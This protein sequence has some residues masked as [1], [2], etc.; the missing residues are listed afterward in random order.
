MPAS[1]AALAGNPPVENSYGST[2][3]TT[4]PPLAAP[5]NS[6]PENACIV[7]TVPIPGTPFD[8]H[9][10]LT[11]NYDCNSMTCPA[12]SKPM[13]LQALWVTTRT[14]PNGAVGPNGTTNATCNSAGCHTAT[15]SGG[16]GN[17]PIPPAANRSQTITNARSE[18]E[19]ISR[20]LRVL[21]MYTRIENARAEARSGGMETVVDDVRRLSD[22]IEAKFSAMLDRAVSLGEMA[23]SARSIAK[24]YRA[25]ERA[26]SAH[27][28][29]ETRGALESLRGLATFEAAV[30][31]RAISVSDRV[32]RNVTEVLVALQVHDA[33]RQII[34]HSIQ[35]LRAFD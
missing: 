11:I 1:A 23:A 14:S 16:A 18:C 20:T 32:V 7:S 4:P 12:V 28:L 25:R 33:T 13:G 35:E 21:G 19:D 17:P 26:W 22:V 10:R 8:Y 30:A 24:D 3:F 6:A 9:C 34:E 15:V 2:A 5:V 27:M 29:D 31:S